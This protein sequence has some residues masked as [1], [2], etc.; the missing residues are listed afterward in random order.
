MNTI[1][2]IRAEIERLKKEVPSAYEPGISEEAAG[3]RTGGRIAYNGLLAF[4]DTPPEQPEVKKSNALFDECVKNCD[5]AVMKEVSDNIDKMLRRQHVSTIMTNEMLM[6][7]I[8]PEQPV[9][10]DLEE[11]KFNDA[12]SDYMEGKDDFIWNGEQLYNIARHF[13]EL[14]KNAK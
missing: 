10:E 12:Y 7:E 11:E 13:Y 2:V 3:F 5:P 6:G 1:E 9:S 8:K 14:G 4:L